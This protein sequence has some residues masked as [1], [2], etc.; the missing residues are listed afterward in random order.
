MMN[1]APNPDRQALHM[2]LYEAITY[3]IGRQYLVILAVADQG[4]DPTQMRG[5][6][7]A[8]Q[9]KSLQVGTWGV[10]WDFTFHGSGCLLRNRRTKEE[11]DWNGPDLASFSPYFFAYHLE[12]R[13][14]QSHDLPLLRQ[15]TEQ[16]G[17]VTVVKLIDELIADGVITEDHRLTPHIDTPRAS[18]A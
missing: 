11:I 9:G 17:I 2:E 3:F 16:H 10:E 1:T 4:I 6:V 12:W 7:G 5:G 8:W 15:F 14:A 18:A 13:L